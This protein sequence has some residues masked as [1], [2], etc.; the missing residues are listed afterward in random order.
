MIIALSFFYNLSYYI[1]PSKKKEVAIMKNIVIDNEMIFVYDTKLEA[2][3]ILET[4]LFECDYNYS[5]IDIRLDCLLECP[6]EIEDDIVKFATNDSQLDESYC[7]M[8]IDNYNYMVAQFKKRKTHKCSEEIFVILKKLAQN[9]H[10]EILTDEE[11]KIIENE[12]IYEKID[13]IIHINQDFDI[14]CYYTEIKEDEESYTQIYKE[15]NFFRV[16]LNGEEYSSYDGGVDD[17]LKVML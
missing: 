5:Y 15:D 11:I 13:A 6:D 4:I 9:N 8:T 1:Y 12:S 17:M 2:D 16:F 3:D 7:Y 10:F 14:E